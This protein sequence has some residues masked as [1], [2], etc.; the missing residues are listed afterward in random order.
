MI[1]GKVG[2]LAD[3]KSGL[4]LRVLIGQMKAFL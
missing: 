3:V 2:D 4:L 1:E